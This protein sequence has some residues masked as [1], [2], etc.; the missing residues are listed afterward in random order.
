MERK[1]VN[2][3]SRAEMI[4]REARRAIDGLHWVL[5]YAEDL[6]RQ[7]LPRTWGPDGPLDVPILVA[8][9]AAITTAAT[10][11]HVEGIGERAARLRRDFRRK[12]LVI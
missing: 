11:L 9:N 8:C 2:A 7:L 4:D 5:T 10:H 12:G 6:Q 3:T 1:G